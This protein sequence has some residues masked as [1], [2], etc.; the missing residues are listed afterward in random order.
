MQKIGR[1]NYRGHKFWEKEILDYCKN[2]ILED[3]DKNK[4][5]RKEIIQR[6]LKARRRDHSFQYLTRHAGKRPREDLKILHKKDHENYIVEIY[7][8]RNEIEGA[9]IEYNKEHY[10]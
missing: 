2:K 8:T 3:T 7:K 4:K 6:L 9:I 10:Q 1:I 5:K